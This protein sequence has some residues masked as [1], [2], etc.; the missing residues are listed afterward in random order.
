MRLK[1]SLT[2]SVS[3][4]FSPR[5]GV[6]YRTWSFLFSGDPLQWQSFWDHF[7]ATIHEN[8]SMSDLDRF[9]YLKRYLSGKALDVV[10]GLS[11]STERKKRL[12]C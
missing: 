1:E 3:N 7:R 9:N 4:V 6:G 2:P 11:L 5:Y 10:S 8:E 12:I